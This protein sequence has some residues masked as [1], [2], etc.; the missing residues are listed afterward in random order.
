MLK[1]RFIRPVATEQHYVMISRVMT[2][3]CLVLAALVPLVR[4]I[5]GG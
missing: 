3:V 5:L 4:P 2:G 1:A